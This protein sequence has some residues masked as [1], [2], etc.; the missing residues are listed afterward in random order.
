MDLDIIPDDVFVTAQ[1]VQQNG[2]ITVFPNYKVNAYGKVIN[3]E[4]DNVVPIGNRG[5]SDM[6]K[7][8]YERVQLIV[9]GEDFHILLHRLVLSSFNAVAQPNSVVNHRDNDEKNNKLS[10]LEWVTSSYNS[11]HARHWHKKYGRNM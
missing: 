6:T 7:K 1:H 5:N 4:T 3:K 9:G 10:N 8:S 11:L 2:T